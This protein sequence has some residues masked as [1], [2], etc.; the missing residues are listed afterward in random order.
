MTS[1]TACLLR[2]SGSWSSKSRRL[3]NEKV[4]KRVV[5][6]RYKG[7]RISGI[8]FLRLV[9]RSPG[10]PSHHNISRGRWRDRAMEGEEEQS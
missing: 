1:D 7:S 2:F 9:G 8:N 10:N 6:E 5:E 4:G 3:S